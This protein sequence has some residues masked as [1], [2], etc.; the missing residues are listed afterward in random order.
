MEK[1][2]NKN[3][4]SLIENEPCPTWGNT[5]Q[6]LLVE[7]DATYLLP[8]TQQSLTDWGVPKDE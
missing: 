8:D 3:E 7:W 5:R 2:H 4:R 6:M 1:E